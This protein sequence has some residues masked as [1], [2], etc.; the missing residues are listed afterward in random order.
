MNEQT[1]KNLA[2]QGKVEEVKQEDSQTHA[3]PSSVTQEEIATAVR[4]VDEY[5]PLIQALRTIKR[6]V[7][8]APTYTPKNFLEQ[9]VFYDDGG[10]TVRLYLY[11]GTTWRY[12]GLT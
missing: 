11:V 9:F 10:G 5:L 7:S 1:L 4:L 6:S 8:T 3:D 2:K 12:V